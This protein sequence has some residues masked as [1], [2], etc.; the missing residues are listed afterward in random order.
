MHHHHRAAVVTITLASAGDVALGTAFGV[1]D[2]IGVADGL[3]FAVTTA[4]TVGYGDI[5]PRGWLAH[6][7]AV[8]MMLLIIP[9][10]AAT[11]SLL[12]SGL[13]STA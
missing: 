8:M 5:T 9:L 7:L 12:T 11:F 4:T 13:T 10:F 6:I 1:A 3:Y 2:R